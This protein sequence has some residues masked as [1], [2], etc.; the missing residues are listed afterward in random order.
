VAVQITNLLHAQVHNGQNA[1]G[2]VTGSIVPPTSPAADAGEDVIAAYND[3]MTKYEKL[4]AI[5]ITIITRKP[6]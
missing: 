1:L 2:I 6:S 3:T 5:A 4:D